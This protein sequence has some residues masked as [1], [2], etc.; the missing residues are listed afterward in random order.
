[1]PVILS[2]PIQ[3][4]DQVLFKATKDCVIYRFA[5]ARET[6]DDLARYRGGPDVEPLDRVAVF[7]KYQGRILQAVKQV[8]VLGRDNQARY[9]LTNQ[10]IP[11]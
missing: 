9:I 10:H 4:D 2:E 7:H 11:T 6:I 8:L 1:M 3:V 5:I